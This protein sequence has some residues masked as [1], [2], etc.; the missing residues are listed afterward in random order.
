MWHLAQKTFSKNFQLTCGLCS[1]MCD[2]CATICG[3]YPSMWEQIMKYDL[4]KSE[5]KF[6]YELIKN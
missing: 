2:P 6:C 4:I 5:P 3:P 1:P